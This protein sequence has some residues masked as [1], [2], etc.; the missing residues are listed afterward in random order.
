MQRSIT[1]KRGSALAAIHVIGVIVMLGSLTFA[2]PVKGA[3]LMLALHSDTQTARIAIDHGALLLGR[4]P[5][6]GS[7]IVLGERSRLRAPAWRAGILLLAAP[8]ALCGKL[9]SS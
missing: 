7:L 3:Y 8:A 5:V 2:P 6:P 4:G 1:G 9:S